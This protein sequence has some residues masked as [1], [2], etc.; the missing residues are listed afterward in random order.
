MRSWYQFHSRRSRRLRDGGWRRRLRWLLLL[1]TSG[2]MSM[3]KRILGNLARCFV[4][5]AVLANVGCGD[6]STPT[7]PA[8]SATRPVNST[9]PTSEGPPSEPVSTLPADSSGPV[10][11]DTGPATEWTC[12]TEVDEKP[13]VLKQIGCER[14]FKALAA[15]PSDSSLPGA[16][17]VKVI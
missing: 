1:C 10:D 8:R 9:A 7:E 13:D 11:T 4:G 15:E 5:V 12:L 16:W 6:D 3:Q 2:M 14:D 17:S